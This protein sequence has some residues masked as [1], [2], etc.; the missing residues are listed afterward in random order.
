MK[1]LAIGDL[2]GKFPKRLRKEFVGK[3][4]SI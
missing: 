1:I 3:I 2:H 4:E